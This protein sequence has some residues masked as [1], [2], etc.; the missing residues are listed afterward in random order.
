MVLFQTC[1]SKFLLRWGELGFGLLSFFYGCDWVEHFVLLWPEFRIPCLSPTVKG[2][3]FQAKGPSALSSA[4]R[5][6]CR[7]RGADSLTAPFAEVSI[8]QYYQLDIQ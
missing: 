4:V 2:M 6:T 5:S 7:A 3:L 1:F 8:N